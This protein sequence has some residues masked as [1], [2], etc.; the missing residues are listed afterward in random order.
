MKNKYIIILPSCFGMS[1]MRSINLFRTMITIEF[2]NGEY[3]FTDAC[4]YGGF[5]FKCLILIQGVKDNITPKAMEYLR[6]KI[7][8]LSNE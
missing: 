3:A 4:K 6:S 1:R 2:Y 5:D 8:R 7:R